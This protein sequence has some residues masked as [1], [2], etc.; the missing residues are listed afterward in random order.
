M[1]ACRFVF[2]AFGGVDFFFA[3]YYNFGYKRNPITATTLEV[4]FLLILKG[5]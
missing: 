2:G 1:Y 4:G 3:S 5:K